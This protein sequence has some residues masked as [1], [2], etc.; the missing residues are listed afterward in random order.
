MKRLSIA[1]CLIFAAGVFFMTVPVDAQT[2]SAEKKT[3]V[4]ACNMKAMTPAQRKRHSEVL[5]PALVTAKRQSSEISNGYAFQFPSDA[6][7]FATVSE[8]I[9]NERLCCPFFE[10]DVHVGDST[11]PLRL[12]ITGPDGV[13]Q[14]IR[15][16][17][18]GLVG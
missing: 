16:E 4:F 10:F 13:K 3:V 9:G 15:A 5:S 12:Q 7:T 18:P 11:E 14:F 1:T 6:K 8:W 17:L 2:P